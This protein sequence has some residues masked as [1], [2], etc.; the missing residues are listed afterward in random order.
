MTMGY[1]YFSCFTRSTNGARGGGQPSLAASFAF[2]KSF[3][4][5][6]FVVRVINAG[7]REELYSKALPASHL[8]RKHPGMF[9]GRPD[10]F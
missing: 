2:N 4:T 10:V 6:E 7:G 8:M 9:V 5:K 3:L 1:A